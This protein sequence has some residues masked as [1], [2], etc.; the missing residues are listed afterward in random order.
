VT[1]FCCDLTV[2]PLSECHETLE[3]AE[4]MPFEYVF[5]DTTEEN[6]ATTVKEHHSIVIIQQHDIQTLQWNNKFWN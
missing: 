6:K 4:L 3:E 5:V 1:D 2:F